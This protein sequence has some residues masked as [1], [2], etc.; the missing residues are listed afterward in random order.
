MVPTAK[1]DARTR[2]VSAGGASE[3]AILSA[4]EL[5]RA[6]LHCREALRRRCCNHQGLP[7]GREK[8]IRQNACT[9]TAHLSCCSK[10][11]WPARA[12]LA[13]SSLRTAP[14]CLRSSLPWLGCCVACWV[15][16]CWRL[17]STS[18]SPAAGWR[19]WCAS[20]TPGKRCWRQRPTVRVD[21]ALRA[22]LVRTDAHDTC[23][24]GSGAYYRILKDGAP[25]DGSAFAFEVC[26]WLTAPPLD[27]E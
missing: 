23:V 19:R 10:H 6:A 22:T 9:S 11:Q 8:T 1:H 27:K 15:W 18:A 3:P 4:R 17:P 12:H 20:T 21:A 2:T 26:F 25:A 16:R 7:R 5:R 14:L 24:P 13:S